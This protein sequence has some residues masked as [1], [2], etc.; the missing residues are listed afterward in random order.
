MNAK[1]CLAQK[2]IILEEEKFVIVSNNEPIS[3]K[4]KDHLFEIEMLTYLFI[5]CIIQPAWKYKS[6]LGIKGLPFQKS[7]G[8][9]EKIYFFPVKAKFYEMSD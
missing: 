3:H 4:Q 8:L 6:L 5:C 2:H 1:G 7:Y 9:L